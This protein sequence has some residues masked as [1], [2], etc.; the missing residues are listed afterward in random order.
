M[1]VAQRLYD[2]GTQQGERRLRELGEEFRHARLSIGLSQQAVADAARIDRGTYSRIERAKLA[3]VSILSAARIASVL[4]LDLSVRVYPG[5]PSI[6]D[7][8][9][10]P[11]LARLLACVGAPLTYRTEVPLPRSER[12]FEQ[13]SWDAVLYGHGERTAVELESRLYD[14]QAQQ[15]RWNLKRRDDAPD[16]FLLVVADTAANRRVLAEYSEQLKDLPRYRTAGVLAAL[17]AGRHPPTGLI[18]LGGST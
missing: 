15:R 4:G 11:R 5:G 14:L 6:R 16:H 8:G 2:R 7:A 1:P 12:A 17:R 18:L 10:A 13:R 3:Y 9:Q